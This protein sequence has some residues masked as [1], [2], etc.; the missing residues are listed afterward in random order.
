M[1]VCRQ[2]NASPQFGVGGVFSPDYGRTWDFE[3]PL[4][5]ALSNGHAAGWATTRQLSDGTLVTIHALEPYHIE[6]AEN[7]RN[8]CHTVRWNL[9]QP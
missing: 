2:F 5:L 9:P 3:H 6:P 7:G 1:T 8:V 4:Q